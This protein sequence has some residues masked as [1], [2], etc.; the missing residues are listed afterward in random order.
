M[1]C[2]E[3]GAL[4]LTCSAATS[5]CLPPTSPNRTPL[6]MASSLKGACT[7]EKKKGGVQDG[8]RREV[9]RARDLRRQQVCCTVKPLQA[10][11]VK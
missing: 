11:H 5:R 10:R 7:R 6:S 1:K 4:V 9:R 3:G 2:N 8:A